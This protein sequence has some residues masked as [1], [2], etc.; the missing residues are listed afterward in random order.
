MP[1]P[2]PIPSC[3]KRGWEYIGGKHGI[4][5]EVLWPKVV[6]MVG[7]L[8]VSVVVE[9]KIMMLHDSKG[10]FLASRYQ[11]PTVLGY[12]MRV[13]DIRVRI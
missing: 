7:G 5:G 8:P 13:H 6:F 11:L 10:N 4:H 1:L 3:P 2:L 12:A 9:A